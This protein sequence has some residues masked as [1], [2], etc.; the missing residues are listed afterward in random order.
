VSLLEPI[1]PALSFIIVVNPSVVLPEVFR[2][3]TAASLPDDTI[4]PNSRSLTATFCP[5]PRN[6]RETVSFIDSRHAFSLIV[7]SVVGVS[8]PAF[9][10]S[11]VR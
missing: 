7:T 6:I 8:L 4:R 1:S 5:T 11:S 9:N 10:A 2:Q 3:A